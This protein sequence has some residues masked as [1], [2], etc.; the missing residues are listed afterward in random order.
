M[1]IRYIINVNDISS[2]RY[3]RTTFASSKRT[4]NGIKGVIKKIRNYF[5]VYKSKTWN[6][7]S[8]VP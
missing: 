5:F 6:F 8:A 7:R 1:E 4:Y 3:C 2:W